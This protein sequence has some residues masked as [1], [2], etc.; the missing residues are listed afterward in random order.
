MS[1]S[2][3]SYFI[4]L[5][6][7]QLI[8]VS[9]TLLP[10]ILYPRIKDH[11]VHFFSNATL[12]LISS[13]ERKCGFFWSIATP[14]VRLIYVPLTRHQDEALC[15]LQTLSLNTALLTLKCMLAN[16]DSRQCLLKEE[17]VNYIICIPW[18]VSLVHRDKAKQIVAILGQ[19]IQLQPPKLSILAKAKLAKMHFG[20][21]RVLQAHSLHDLFS[22][23][24]S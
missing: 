7:A 20:L 15:S 3:L 13:Q 8:L 6:L 10:P 1:P 14:Y 19:Y 23:S 9:P 21:E 2:S 22:N 16:T 4:Q 12:D 11:M 5:F 17:L 24:T 18:D